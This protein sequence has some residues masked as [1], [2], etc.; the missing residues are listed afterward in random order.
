LDRTDVPKAAELMQAINL[1]IGDDPRL[2][3]ILGIDREKVAAGIALKFKE[4][5]PLLERVR[6]GEVSARHPAAFGYLFL[7]KFIQ[8][9]F[10]VPRPSESGIKE[11]LDSLANKRDEM[12]LEET[13]KEAEREQRKEQRRHV[14]VRSR[15]DSEEV[16]TL[17]RLVAPALQWN[18]RRMKQFINDFRLQAYI[19]SDLRMLD[20]VSTDDGPERASVTLEQLG[21]FVAITMAWPD[22]V[23]DFVEFPELLCSIYAAERF[24]VESFLKRSVEVE[25]S[26]AGKEYVIPL[27]ADRREL[28][29]RWSAERTLVSLLKAVVEGKDKARYSLEHV[30][31]RVLLNISPKVQSAKAQRAAAQGAVASGTNANAPA[32]ARS[33]VPASSAASGFA[34]PGEALENEGEHDDRDD[35][36]EEEIASVASAKD[37]VVSAPRTFEKQAVR[38]AAARGAAKK[39]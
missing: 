20:L 10:R 32:N 13:R 22:L 29:Q 8:I 37:T 23:M 2:V 26:L 35:G 19:A 30:D 31:V 3:F 28:I 11:F 4:I 16:Q 33:E 34:S 12:R 7:E 24:G 17:I 27:N 5:Q 9:T 1:M 21:K 15:A 38:R 39:K 6:E 25:I 18:P 36:D 14:D